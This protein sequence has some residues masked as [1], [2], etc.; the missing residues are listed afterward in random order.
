MDALR[1]PRAGGPSETAALLAL[2]DAQGV[3]LVGLRALVDRFGSAEAVLRQRPD[4]CRDVC[5]RFAPP[6]RNARRAADAAF[7]SAERL[8]MAIVTWGDEAYPQTLLHLHDPPP[9]LF[10]RGRVELLEWRSITVVGARRATV[11]SRDVA[12]RLGGAAARAGICVT[13]GMAL[14]IDGAAHRGALV[15]GG[16]TTA[17]LGR[18]ADEPYPP[19]HRRLFRDIVERGLV[20]SEFRPGTPPLPHHFPRRNRIL[21]ALSSA[22]VVVEAGVRSGSL[23][24]VDHALDLG[25][26]VWA[27]PGPIDLAACRGSNRLL[28]EGARPLLHV[29]DFVR[30]LTGRERPPVSTPDGLGGQVLAALIDAPLDAGELA[31]RMGLP[32]ADVL[33]LLTEL[34]LRGAVR[35]MPGMRF[36]A[37]A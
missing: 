9:V 1:R 36:S 27:V 18:G 17:V 32:V 28:S 16:D 14:G 15:A 29:D 8:G 20:V 13:S 5:P 26:D 31:R 35:R 22:V 11:R 23:I 37:A 6:D 24:T 33:G 19:S 30:E 25:R 34:E 4:R 21:A 3:G 10:L 7:E 2:E 12:E